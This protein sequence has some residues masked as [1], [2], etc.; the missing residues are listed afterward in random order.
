MEI[1]PKIEKVVMTPNYGKFI[2]EPLHRGYGVTI[3]NSL[4]R[5]LL[6]LLSGAAV[7]YVKIEGVLHEFSTLPGIVEDVTEIILNLKRLPMKMKNCASTVLYLESH[8]QK[9]VKASDIKQNS[10]VEI[11]E[12]NWH[13]ATLTE[14]NAKLY[15]EI[16]VSIGKGYVPAEKQKK[17]TEI[18]IIPVDSIFS[19]I[20]KVNYVVEDARVGQI[21][22]YNRLIIEIWTN[23]S[24]A[25]DEALSRASSILIEHFS[26]LYNLAP[27]REEEIMIES[28]EKLLKTKIQDLTFSRRTLNCFKKA[29]IETVG[30]LVKYSEEELMK[31]RSFG[32]SSL[33]EVKKRLT[34]FRL[35]LREE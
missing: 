6:S 9:E 20:T 22:D 16:W 28:P 8:G 5:T 1:Q 34:S 19:P 18:G 13:I 24:I 30:D 35:S 14:K 32:K 3:G 29:K 25:P 7:T 2:I 11:L 23:G 21:T 26:L 33:D 31:I 12:P 27:P 10:D 4:R 15:M 17:T